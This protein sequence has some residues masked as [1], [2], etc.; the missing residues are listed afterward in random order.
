MNYTLGDSVI[1]SVFK[2]LQVGIITDKIS[3]KT[4]N[5][6]SIRAEDTKI[7]DNVYVNRITD[8]VFINSKL[9]Q[10]FNKSK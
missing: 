6:Y 4:T 3:T 8:E 9:T 5:R 10:S 1:I 2:K 7:Y